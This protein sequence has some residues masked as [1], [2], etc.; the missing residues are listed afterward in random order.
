MVFARTATGIRADVG[1]LASQIHPVFML[2]PIAASW[3]G[4]IVAGAPSIPAGAV[5]ALAAFF[6]VYTA[7]VKDGYVDFHLRGEDDDH[8]MTAD[9]CRIAL[10]G[11]SLGFCG[12][13][14]GVWLLAGPAAA[15]L[16]LPMWVIGYLHAPQLDTT[17]VGATMGYPTGIAVAMVGGYVVQTGAV[18]S[19]G[20]GGG[21]GGVGG[22]ADL[23]GT[24]GPTTILAFA[25]VFLVVL[26]GV[27]V[28]DDE[29]DH[30][31]D[32][33]IDKRTVAVLLG[34]ERARRLAYGLFA[35][36]G[37]MVLWGTVS[38][39]FSPSAPAAVAV[40]AT[41]AV[42]AY[43]APSDLATMLLIRGTYLFLALLVVATWY[44][45]LDPVGL[46]DVTALGPVTYLATEAVFGTVAFGL[47][48][49]ANALRRARVTIAA[50]Y[51]VAYVW[52][53]YTLEVGVFAIVTRTG[54]DLF[55][56]PI[57]EHLFM[58]VVPAFVLGVHETIRS[59]HGPAEA[60][61]EPGSE[62]E[63]D[64]G[65]DGGAGSEGRRDGS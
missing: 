32:A 25:A 57:E 42:V 8:P 47:L 53:W 54:Y 48:Y 51:P 41:V 40:F 35:L 12:C 23:G 14:V 64:D 38:G 50:I 62:A 5:H 10:L 19:V 7:H 13:L 60:G 61:G 29:S 52:D 55:G 6:A 21:S 1:A 15:A 46:P 49:R 65:T 17:P 33:S 59:M 34:P 39:V 4:A 43:R 24:G 22:I 16:V 30:A 63:A 27:K 56:I 28:V 31:Y 37:T 36:G 18:A 58:V 20:S 45:P 26:T 2:P 3:F 44:R 11:A 9:G